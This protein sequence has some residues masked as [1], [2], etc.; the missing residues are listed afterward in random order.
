MSGGDPDRLA[1]LLELCRPVV[2]EIVVALDDRVDTALVGRACELADSV[3]RMPYEPPP[4]RTLPW[5]YA[6]C[7]G[8]WILK[9][10][11]DEVPSTPCSRGFARPRTRR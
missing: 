4:E 8:D 2:D 1:A 10:D 11:D 7:T 5:L 9:L 3:V 6:Q